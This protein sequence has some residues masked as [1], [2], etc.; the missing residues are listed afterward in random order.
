MR[1]AVISKA[2]NLDIELGDKEWA[3]VASGAD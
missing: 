2:M 3:K 1:K